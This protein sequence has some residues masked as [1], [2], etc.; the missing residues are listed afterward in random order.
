MKKFLPAALILA[1]LVAPG[2]SAQIAQAP[3]FYNGFEVEDG[4][5]ATNEIDHGGPGRD[6][7]PALI[8]PQRQ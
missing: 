8:S 3:S 1:S 2:V 4:L 5:I 6:G 7:I